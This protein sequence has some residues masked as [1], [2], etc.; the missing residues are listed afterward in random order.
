MTQEEWLRRY[1]ARI[2]EKSGCTL[3]QAKQFWVCCEFSDLSDGYK[4]DPESAADEDMAYAD[5]SSLYS[6][7]N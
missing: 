4:D 1:E 3:A 6:E 7:E 5:C 2:V